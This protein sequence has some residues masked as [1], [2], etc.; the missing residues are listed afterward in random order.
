MGKNLKGGYQV[1]DL[2]NIDLT[3]TAEA[4]NITDVEVL[5]QLSTLRD[6]IEPSHNYVKPLKKKLKPIL[7][8]IRDK[9][10]DEEQESSIWA[11]L[12][13][14]DDEL[15]YKIE[16]VVNNSPLKVLQINVVFEL[17]TEED[18]STHY[19]IDIATVLLSELV[20]MG[21]INVEGITSKG[22]A[23]TGG[24]ANIG[25]VAISGELS[26]SGDTTVGDLS[27]NENKVAKIFENIVD[28]DGHKRFVEGDIELPDNV[29]FT[30]EYG[31]W[32]L[33]GT[34]LL[35]VLVLD[36]PDGTVL[37]GST[38]F[39]TFNLPKW[40]Y[41]KI[42]VLYGTGRV[43]YKQ[44]SLFA[45]D[46]TFQSFIGLLIKSNDENNTMEL[47]F[48]GTN[49]TLTADRRVKITFDILIDNEEQE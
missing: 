6:Y 25:N 5:E 38:I 3:L 47:N 44:F 28:K 4:Q 46:A 21:D 49:I 9:K 31:K 32:S 17:V 42:V 24:L 8:S 22:I 1:I 43:D 26:V 15:S 2:R 23:N 12:S 35:I 33:S 39:G 30:K 45:D 13:L 10:S 37:G 27:L 40:I 20:K 34:H 48:R 14:N 7:I 41:D 29:P 19:E 36:V 11:N 18:G 16:A